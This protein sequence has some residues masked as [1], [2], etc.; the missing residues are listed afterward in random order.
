VKP[1]RSR[2]E[3]KFAPGDLGACGARVILEAGVLAFHPGTIFLGDDVYVGHYT[4]L[5]GYHDGPG[6]R[7]GA[8]TWIGPQCYLH[9]AGGITIGAD[10]GIGPGVRILTSTHADP[11][12]DQPI[13]AGAIERAPV[14]IEDGADIGIGAILLPGAHVGKGA[15]IGAGAVVSGEVPAFAVA[16]GVPARVLR[17]RP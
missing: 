1:F 14:V 17:S 8:G 13:M 11:G 3:G 16:A 5:H 10:V 7:I 9:S 6:M 12:R 4:I 15:Q 2:G